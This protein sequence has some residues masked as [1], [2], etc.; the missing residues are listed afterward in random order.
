MDPAQANLSSIKQQLTGGSTGSADSHG[1][2]K[3]HSSALIGDHTCPAPV[4]KVPRVHC[5]GSTLKARVDPSSVISR[6]AS[7]HVVS[8]PEHAAPAP[9]NG[10]APHVPHV[11]PQVP[12]VAPVSNNPV[13]AAVSS[14]G[15]NFANFADFDTAA[16]DSLPPGRVKSAAL[17]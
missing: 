16:F 3:L 10:A 4:Y 9:T 13:A 5:P 1:S 2:H 11:A 7:S 12:H 6:P 15:D 17:L 14:A 8:R